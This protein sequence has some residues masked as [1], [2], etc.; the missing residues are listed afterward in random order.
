ME[1]LRMKQKE[2][3][4]ERMKKLG[5]M[6]QPIKEF[7]DEDILNLSEVAGYLYWLDDDEKE[8]VKKFE[9][10]NNALVY[11]IIKTNTNIG[12]LYNLLYVSEYV[13]EWDMDMDDLSER[14]ALAYVLNKTMPD[15]SEFGTIGIQ[16]VNGGLMRSW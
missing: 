11:H 2:Q 15:C 12:M 8:M 9:E 16:L 7:E 3:A 13:E 1:D 10:E 5:I 6:E 4:I 14:Q